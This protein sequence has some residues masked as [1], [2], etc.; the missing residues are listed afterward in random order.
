M[1]Y[2]YWDWLHIRHVL[3]LAPAVLP[4]RAPAAVVL[5]VVWLLLSP[6]KKGN[7]ALSSADASASPRFA[8]RNKRY[9]FDMLI[10]FN[11]I[12]F[13]SCITK[14]FGMGEKTDSCVSCIGLL[15]LILGILAVIFTGGLMAIPGVGMLAIGC[16]LL[17]V[18][19]FSANLCKY[20]FYTMLIILAISFLSNLGGK[21]EP[22]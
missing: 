12:S 22:K 14:R 21:Y 7:A 18:P 19:K 20:G 15:L 17:C 4:R 13:D 3:L 10:T 6:L 11:S 16:F 2:N 5:F 9:F 1:I 8:S